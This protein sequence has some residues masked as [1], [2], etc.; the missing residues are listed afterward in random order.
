MSMSSGK[1]WVSVDTDDPA[2]PFGSMFESANPQSFTDYLEGAKSLEDLGSE[3]VDGVETTH[4]QLTVSTKKLLAGNEQLSSMA[5]QAMG[6][7]KKLKINVWLNADQLP[8]Q[9]KLALAKLGSFETH[10]S[11][12][13]KQVEVQAPPAKLVSEMGAASL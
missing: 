2:S 4:Y 13:G 10:F 7:P 6:M 8:V 5:P 12:Y 3:T 11:D 9:M 1:P